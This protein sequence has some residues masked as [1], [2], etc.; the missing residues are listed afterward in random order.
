MHTL[1]V[2]RSGFAVIGCVVSVH[3]M[4]RVGATVVDVI[5]RWRSGNWEA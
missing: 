1:E 2:M 3:F 5:Q 4:V